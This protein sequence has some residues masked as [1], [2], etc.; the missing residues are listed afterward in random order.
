MHVLPTRENERKI[1]R[2]SLGMLWKR[3]EEGRKV[4]RSGVGRELAQS[5]QPAVFQSPLRLTAQ[6]ILPLTFSYLTTLTAPSQAKQTL[7]LSLFPLDSS[8]VYP[9]S[10]RPDFDKLKHA[11]WD[12]R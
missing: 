1:E 4:L 2:E 10:Y 11:E 9:L 8:V 5:P 7:C 6:Y 12:D 3:V